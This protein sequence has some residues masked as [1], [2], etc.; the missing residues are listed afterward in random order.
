MLLF[1]LFSVACSNVILPPQFPEMYTR[2]SMS[3]LKHFDLDSHVNVEFNF[4]PVKLSHNSESERN[5]NEKFKIF[6]HFLLSIHG[7]V[8][9]EPEHRANLYFYLPKTKNKKYRNDGIKIPDL[10]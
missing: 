3:D 10:I 8:V 4:W 1:I 9:C 5:E 6:S 7:R 2:S